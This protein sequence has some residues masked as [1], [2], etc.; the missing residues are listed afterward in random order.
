MDNYLDDLLENTDQ[1][2]FNRQAREGAGRQPGEEGEQQEQAEVVKE[3]K[4]KKKKK[5]RAERGKSKERKKKDRIEIQGDLFGGAADV[6]S[7]EEQNNAPVETNK[8]AGE[9]YDIDSVIQQT[10]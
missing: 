7:G 10:Q 4:R 5:D 1:L 6:A 9:E 2:D 3:K 8:R